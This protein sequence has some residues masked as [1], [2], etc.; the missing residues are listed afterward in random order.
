MGSEGYPLSSGYFPSSIFPPSPHCQP[1]QYRRRHQPTSSSY[2]GVHSVMSA[3]PMRPLLLLDPKLRRQYED[4][5]AR[6]IAFQM[7]TTPA[8]EKSNISN[9]LRGFIAAE[10]ARTREGGTPLQIKVDIAYDLVSLLI[11]TTKCSLIER[12]PHVELGFIPLGTYLQEGWS[13]HAAGRDV[14]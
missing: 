12:S 4:C 8:V 6:K 3:H 14:V 9:M 7:M 2:L 1:P 10:R 5:T 13:A 11:S